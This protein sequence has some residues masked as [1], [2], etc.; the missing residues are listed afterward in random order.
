LG[1]TAPKRNSAKKIATTTESASGANASVT[2]DSRAQP[3]KTLQHAL[4]IVRTEEYANEENAF[5]APGSPEP[6]VNLLCSVHL[7]AITEENAGGEGATASQGSAVLTV[8]ELWT[9]QMLVVGGD[10]VWTA[11]VSANEVGSENDVRKKMRK[12]WFASIIVTVT[13][14]AMQVNASVKRAGPEK[15]VQ[16]RMNTKIEL[17][18]VSLIFFLN[19]LEM[20]SLKKINIPS[21]T[22]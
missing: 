2:L 6:V 4:I 11:S 13:A 16:L 21:W 9:A 1:R 15:A 3:A 14:D 19:L 7:I 18:K 12:K 8:E 10:F 22:K 17:A 5:A 20:K